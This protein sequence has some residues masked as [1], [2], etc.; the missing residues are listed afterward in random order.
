[1]TSHS[2]IEFETSHRDIEYDIERKMRSMLSQYH[3]RE[4]VLI[5]ATRTEKGVL[6]YTWMHVGEK[7]H[8]HMKVGINYP[9]EKIY[10]GDLSE[11]VL[12]MKKKRL[13]V[14]KILVKD[15]EEEV[16]RDEDA[17]EDLAEY[18]RIKDKNDEYGYASAHSSGSKDS[19]S[20]GDMKDVQRKVEEIDTSCQWPEDKDEVMELFKEQDVI[21]QKTDKNYEKNRKKIRKSSSMSVK[22]NKRSRVTKPL[23]DFSS[24]LFR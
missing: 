9:E 4:R 7:G 22:V 19:K 8:L 24:S 17:L 11:K 14:M 5:D 21:Q 20:V 16:E 3:G 6:T 23:G 10:R 18:E 15:L 2:D 13:E 12:K 1:M